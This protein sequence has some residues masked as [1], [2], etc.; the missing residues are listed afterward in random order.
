VSGRA[1]QN[2]AAEVLKQAGESHQS[3]QQWMRSGAEKKKQRDETKQ[4]ETEEM[5]EVR[6]AVAALKNLQ[7]QGP[8]SRGEEPHH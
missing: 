8:C 4:H 7:G 5:E 2:A 6:Q 3:R 1:A